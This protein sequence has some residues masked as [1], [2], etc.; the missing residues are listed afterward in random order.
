VLRLVPNEHLSAAEIAAAEA[1][2]SETINPQTQ[3]RIT[4]ADTPDVAAAYLDQLTRVAGVEA[5][6]AGQV[7]AGIDQWRRGGRVDRRGSAALAGLLNEASGK[8][9]GLNKTRLKSLADLFERRGR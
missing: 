3:T 5:E 6:L 2:T 9:A 1:V 7:Q 4:W 8:A